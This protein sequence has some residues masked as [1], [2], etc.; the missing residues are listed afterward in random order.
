M[1]G[2]LA[3]FQ[4]GGG[5]TTRIDGLTGTER[6]SGTLDGGDSG[7]LATHVGNFSNVFHTVLDQFLGILFGHFVLESARACDVA[8]HAPSLLAG[9]EFGF[10]R[11]FVGHI[12]NLVAVGGTH[13]Q[14]VV[15]HLFGDAVGDFADTVRTGDGNHL[16]T[17][18]SGLDG[19]TPSHVTEAGEGDALAF[20]LVVLLFH[21][22]LHIVDGTETGGFRTNQ[23]AA[24]AVALA[25]QSAGAVLAGQFL[26]GTVEVTDFTSANADV[27]GRAVLIRTDVAP[28][29]IHE[30]LAETHDFL[31]RLANGVE[32]GTALATAER[33]VG[34]GV[35]EDLLESQELQ[36]GDVDSLVEAE[37]A[38]VC[39]EGGVELYTVTQV[40]LDFAIA[41]NPSHTERENTIGLDQAL[42]DF[43]LFKFRMLVIHLFD[44]F[45]HFANSLQVF[46]FSR[47][48]GL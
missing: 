16:G 32:I 11:E 3:D 4:T 8:L 46:A 29:L 12:L 39:T 33:Q 22:A 28:Q 1:T 13:I 10:A 37:T 35:F 42:H 2:V 27:T 7:G 9:S 19:G 44:G 18:L 14:H 17:K 21:H 40:G 43:R 48:F 41:V 24:P 36:H 6:N 23:G 15:N 30:G 26:V 20:H 38:F 5:D 31:V 34:Q 45:Q 47:M 25:G